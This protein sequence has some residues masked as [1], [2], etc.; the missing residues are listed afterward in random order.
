MFDFWIGFLDV[1]AANPKT[2]TE[3]RGFLDFCAHYHLIKLR[4]S[5]KSWPHQ[6][7]VQYGSVRLLRIV[8][9]LHIPSN[10]FFPISP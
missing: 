2:L 7:S 8:V 4:I 5:L 6:K 3:A 1:A 9:G 10:F